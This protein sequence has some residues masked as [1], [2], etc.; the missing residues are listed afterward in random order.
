MQPGI[1]RPEQLKN[2]TGIPAEVTPISFWQTVTGVF[3]WGAIRQRV[4]IVRIFL[5]SL[6]GKRGR[7]LAVN[8]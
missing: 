5:A 1:V 7:P 4:F 8:Y 3:F 2:N 6:C